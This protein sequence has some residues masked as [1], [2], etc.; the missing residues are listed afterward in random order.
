MDVEKGIFKIYA[1]DPLIFGAVT[2]NYDCEMGGQVIR[3]I[4]LPQTMTVSWVVRLHERYCYHK[5]RL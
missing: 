2:T 5:L 4:L 1:N 3:E